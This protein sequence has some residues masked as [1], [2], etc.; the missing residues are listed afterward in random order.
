MNGVFCASAVEIDV[1]RFRFC[2]RRKK[3]NLLSSISHVENESHC[4]DFYAYDRYNMRM[5]ATD[6][7]RKKL[8]AL[9]KG[10][11]A[12]RIVD[13]GNLNPGIDLRRVW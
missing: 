2:A 12:Y 9:K 8:Y 11:G 13:L 10:T 3:V 7:I 1:R 4:L 6:E 5:A